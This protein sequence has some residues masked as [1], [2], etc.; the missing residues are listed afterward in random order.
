MAAEVAVASGRSGAVV[1]RAP[2]EAGARAGAGGDGGAC[3][4]AGA[5]GRGGA[6]G[7]AAGVPVLVPAG[8]APAAHFS[9][10]AISALALATQRSSAGRF[11]MAT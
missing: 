2:V 4:A 1:A 10:A 9:S 8:R 7:A 3:V 5:A 6:G 11:S